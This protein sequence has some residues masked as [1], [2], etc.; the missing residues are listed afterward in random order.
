MCLF[1]KK[2]CTPTKATAPIRGWKLVTQV[3]ET[4]WRSIIRDSTHK[5]N[6]VIQAEYDENYLTYSLGL[7]TE[8]RKVPLEQLKPHYIHL[9]VGCDPEVIEAGLHAVRD[10]RGVFLI[11]TRYKWNTDNLFTKE[12]KRMMK[13][14][15][16][17]IPEGAEY[18]LGEDGEIVSTQM[19]VFDSY[20][21]YK[22]Y[23]R[24][25]V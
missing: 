15:P 1:I 12:Q 20:G 22:K 8:T 14:V 17:V 25:R 18:C 3:S 21:S 10:I 24:D 23:M 2:G 4:E 16:V 13:L 5:F 19:I 11:Y 9:G 7:S 6:E